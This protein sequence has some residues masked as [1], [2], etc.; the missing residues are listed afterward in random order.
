MGK[1]GSVE[2]GALWV[3]HSLFNE[4]SSPVPFLRLQPS[5]SATTLESLRV[6]FPPVPAK[7]LMKWTLIRSNNYNERLVMV[8]LISG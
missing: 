4:L 5:R 1:G 7:I 2:I 6:P 8:T 3:F